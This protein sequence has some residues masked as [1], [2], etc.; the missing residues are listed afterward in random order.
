MS[1]IEVICMYCHKDMGIKPGKGVNGVSHGICKECEPI[2]ERELEAIE[3]AEALVD[4]PEIL[5]EVRDRIPMVTE[6]EYDAGMY[7]ADADELIILDV[8]PEDPW[9]Y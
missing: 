1:T 5:D 3:E 9:S 8:E 7:P 2:M 6:A 4:V